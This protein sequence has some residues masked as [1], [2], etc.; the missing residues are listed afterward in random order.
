M[1]QQPW[2]TY[3]RIDNFGTIDP[4]GPYYKPDSNI[5]IPGYYP[6]T[7][8][9]PG[10]ITSLQSTGYG[11]DIA[12]I[13]LD[14]PLNQ[15]ATHTFYEHLSSFVSGLFVGKHVS[16][17][18]TIGYNNPPG[19]VPL[20]FGLYSGDVYGSGPGWSQLQQDLAPGG[21]GLLN[22]TKLL[23]NAKAGQPL[24]T[25]N[26][27]PLYTDSGQGSC[28][29]LIPGFPEIPCGSTQNPEQQAGFGVG[30]GAIVLILFG[31][32]IFIKD[33]GPAKQATQTAKVAAVAV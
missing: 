17:G 19:Q 12:T 8:L 27:P 24:N 14:Q 11:Q 22:P 4:E 1:A 2:Y 6:V 25:C 9:L 16:A 7:A 32:L 15:E 31:L 5:Q 28:V 20:G 29:S 13:K 21:P 10:T 3:P 18:Q 33:S 26:C 23:N 30:I